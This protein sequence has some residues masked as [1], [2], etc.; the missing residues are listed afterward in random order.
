MIVEQI[1]PVS[2]SGN[3]LGPVWRKRMLIP[4]LFSV[5]VLVRKGK[6]GKA[7]IVIIDH[8]LYETLQQK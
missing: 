5:E 7:D 3:V 1:L 8:G 4:V 6:D 2:T